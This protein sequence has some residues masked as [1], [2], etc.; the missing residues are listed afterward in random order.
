MRFMENKII[1]NNVS[2]NNREVDTMP[3][4]ELI[5]CERVAYVKGMENY[6][7]KL[8][9]MPNHEAVRRSRANLQNCHIIQDNGELTDKYNNSRMHSEE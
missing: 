7:Q 4:I 3:A 5:E 2:L 9:S 6:L 1:D 8:K